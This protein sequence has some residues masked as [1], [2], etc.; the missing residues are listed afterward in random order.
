MKSVPVVSVV[1]ESGAGKT[2][3]LEK[4]IAEM[5]ARNFRVGVIK[6]HVHDIEIDRPGKDTWRHSRAG[7]DTVAISTPGKVALFRRVEGEMEL[8]HLVGILG[9]V[10]IIFT[11]GYKRGNKPKIEISRLEHSK[12]LISDQADLIAIVSDTGWDVGVPVFGLEEADRVA[13]FLVS[14]YNLKKP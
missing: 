1:G 9:D 11:E 5:K 8:D 12:K 13:D 6:H 3:F 7:A 4:L 14:R 2:T 10:D